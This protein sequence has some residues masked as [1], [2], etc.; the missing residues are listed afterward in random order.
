VRA[1]HSPETFEA[2]AAR[3][4]RHISAEQHPELE[5]VEA[6]RKHTDIGP[7]MP[8]YAQEVARRLLP[9]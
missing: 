5:R 3:A 6:I 7:R 1:A 4:A 9:G 8:P 2:L